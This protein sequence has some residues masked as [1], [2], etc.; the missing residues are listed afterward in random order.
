[1]ARSRLEETLDTVLKELFP[2]DRFVED[3]PIKVR[4]RTLFVDRVLPTRKL[5][6]EIDGRQHLE[7]VQY[8]HKDH[9][10]FVSHK[11]RD[12]VKTEWL[13]TNHYTLIRLA[14]NDKIT[15]KE[16]RARI[17]MALGMESPNGRRSLKTKPISD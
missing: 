17:L 11:E 12:R 15:V 13:A 3:W 9:D 5:A 7:Y 4:G 2:N 1:M 10:G 8:F 14:H 6:F 16:V